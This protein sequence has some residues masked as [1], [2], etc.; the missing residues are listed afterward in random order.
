[1]AAFTSCVPLR[2]YVAETD[3]EYS[4]HFVGGISSLDETTCG[5]PTP[6]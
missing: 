4:R 3:L 6:Y 5:I 2:N 1:M